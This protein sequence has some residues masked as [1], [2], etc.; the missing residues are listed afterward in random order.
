MDNKQ[1]LTH[2][3]HTQ[4]SPTASTSDY[5][6]LCEEG[7]S[8]G[9]ASVCVPASRVELCASH[10]AGQAVG[11]KI[12]TVVGFPHGYS[13]TRAKAF[14]AETAIRQG[15][16][17]IDMVIDIGQAK[18][19]NYPGILAD[20]K[21]IRTATEGYILKVIIETALL[22]Q[23]EKIALCH[24]VSESGADFIKTST[25]FASGGATFD[26]VI[27]LRKH[28]APEVRVKAAGGIATLDDAYRFVAL[29]ADRLGT[30]RVV[31][32]VQGLGGSGY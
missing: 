14:E 22:T 9:V 2:V 12:C 29:G 1:L 23:E 16:A 10:M 8:Y 25:G 13:D 18:E 6:K 26:D 4:L 27:L 24:V 15:A 28:V 30:S 5:I 19:H 31:R 3:D 7:V 32:L 21:A 11:V 17:E 20:I